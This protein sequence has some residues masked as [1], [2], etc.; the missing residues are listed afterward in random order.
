M[1]DWKNILVKI[2]W[3]IAGIALIVL[4]TYAW[5]DKSH[6]KCTGVQ[7]ELVGDNTSILF[8]DELEIKALLA[9]QGVKQGVPIIELNL[10]KIE[11]SLANI[12]WIK[13][14][15]I[16]IDNKQEVQVR[17][18]QRI[19]V[20]RIFTATGGSF[21]IDSTAK[22]LPLKQL[23]VMRLPVITGFPSDQEKLSKP[24]SALLSHVLK[25]AMLIRKD[26]FFS[27]QVAQVNITSS[28][29][30]EIIPA[31][32]DHLVLIGSIENI[33]D[34]LNRLY[35]FY[36][37]VWIQSGINAYQVLDC[38]FDHQIV[39]LKKGMQPI[40]FAPGVLPFANFNGDTLAIQMPDTSALKMATVTTV[41]LKDPDTLLVAKQ[42]ITVKPLKP[43][44]AVK[45][46]ATT[47][48]KMKSK[49]TQKVVKGSGKKT[50]IKKNNKANNKT[51]NKV[52]KTAKAILPKKPAS[53]KTN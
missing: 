22:Q 17:I 23:T 35:T 25:L 39:A 13:N 44:V 37:K 50:I 2:L 16:F 26:S 30:L 9:E 14:A 28:G 5:Q 46:G 12:K 51:L 31:L 49:T 45:K 41:E 3:S 33:E 47:K 43:I 38:R 4:F 10:V 15:E 1:K 29:D 48:S 36:K 24:D 18:E 32:G 21:F 27:A 53:K 42:A 34:K 8:M 52:K 11:Q 6:K 20:A 40:Y 7:I 19:P